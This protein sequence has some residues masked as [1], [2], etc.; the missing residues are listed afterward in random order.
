MV[1]SRRE[2]KF[3]DAAK[4][5]SRTSDYHNAHVGCVVAIKNNILSVASNSEKT[6][7]LQKVYNRYRDFDVDTM[8]CKLHAEICA[9]SLLYK[10]PIDWVHTEVYVYREWRNGKPAISR[11][12]PACMGLIKDLGIKTIIYND[13]NGNRVKEFV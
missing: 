10:K 6:H 5:I 12:C 7:T 2:N 1:L 3:M 11:P 9:L 13:I 4:A 8:P